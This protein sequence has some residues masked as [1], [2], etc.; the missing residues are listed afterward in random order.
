MTTSATNQKAAQVEILSSVLFSSLDEAHFFNSIN[1]HFVEKF[2]CHK[3]LVYKLLDNG[4]AQLMSVNGEAK[5]NGAILEKG[6]GAAGYVARTKKGYFSNTVER[7]PVFT[8]EAAAGVKAELC[9]PISADGTVIGSIHCQQM[10]NSKEF[11]RNDMTLGMSII[12]E[13]KAPIQNMKM[14]LAAKNLNESLLKTIE[15][16]EKELQQ[17]RSGLKLQD[18]FIINEKEIIGRSAS[19]KEILNLVD[20]ISDKDITAFIYGE[21]ATGKEMI[22]RRIH[23]RS[24]RKENAFVSLDCSALNEKQLEVE[25]FGNDSHVGMLEAANNGTLFINSIDKMSLS[26]QNKLMQYMTSKMGIKANGQSFFK[27]DV[28]IIS[29]STRDLLDLVRI[30]AFKEDLYF[31]LSTIVLKAP[32]LRERKEDIEV[33]ANFFLNQNKAAN[34]QKS[35]SPSAVKALTEYAW[36]GNV[37]ELQNIV[38]RAYILAEGS[39]IEKLHLDQTVQNAEVAP[40]VEKVVQVKASDFVP[41]TL[42][43]LEKNHIMNA[44]ENLS[45]N[46]TKTAKVLGITVKTLYNKLHSYGIEFDKEA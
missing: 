26:V 8:L 27:S 35:F 16:K 42:E 5:A 7:D 38:E 45:G 11:S 44:L 4:Q 34:A 30:D 41:V 2:N 24:H 31:A 19:M 36:P 6:V 21:A 22:A 29:A 43:E 13:I 15:I 32:A 9:L 23:C 10:D 3:V 39:I 28:R 20:R 46:K 17:S 14:Y 18:T 25:L 33:L 12:N 37:R 40:V 1:K